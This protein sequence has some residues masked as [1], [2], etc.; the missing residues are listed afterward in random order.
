MCTL[1]LVAGSEARARRLGLRGP[2]SLDRAIYRLTTLNPKPSLK[3]RG[4]RLAGA[5]EALKS[6]KIDEARSLETRAANSQIWRLPKMR[7]TILEVPIMKIS[8]WGSMWGHSS[9]FKAFLF[10]R[11]SNS[12]GGCTTLVLLQTHARSAAPTN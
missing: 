2:L 3:Q 12:S 1:G 7:G 9:G 10:L 5:T 4:S 11:T 8:I 6:P